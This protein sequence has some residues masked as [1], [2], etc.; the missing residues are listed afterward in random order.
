MI[1]FSAFANQKL[2]YHLIKDTKKGYI[3]QRHFWQISNFW[4]KSEWIFYHFWLPWELQFSEL[5]ACM[6]WINYFK[7]LEWPLWQSKM[8]NFDSTSLKWTWTHLTTSLLPTTKKISSSSSTWNL[9]ISMNTSLVCSSGP[10]VTFERFKFVAMTDKK[11]HIIL[12]ALVYPMICY[13]PPY[14]GWWKWSMCPSFKRIL[15]HSNHHLFCFVE[16]IESNWGRISFA[17][18][19]KKQFLFIFFNNPSKML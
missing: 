8:D 15:N 5:K 14:R 2:L 4:V 3:F 18:N 1:K 16:K 19:P 11:N 13:H 17:S 12:W 10:S 7:A 9:K 6:D